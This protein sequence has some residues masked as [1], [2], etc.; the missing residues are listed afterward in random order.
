MTRGQGPSPSQILL[1][2][3]GSSGV[4][5]SRWENKGPQSGRAQGWVQTGGRKRPH[6]PGVPVVTSLFKTAGETGT[7]CQTVGKDTPHTSIGT[8]PGA[9]RLQQKV[10]MWPHVACPSPKVWELQEAPPLPPQACSSRRQTTSGYSFW[11][12]PG[13]QVSCCRTPSLS[14]SCREMGPEPP[15]PC[16]LSSWWQVSP[17]RW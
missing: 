13:C 2:R 8:N 1:S 15:N 17:G 4:A 5:G 6:L 10:P 7:G 14:H 9:S 16:P 12:F 3:P 11:I